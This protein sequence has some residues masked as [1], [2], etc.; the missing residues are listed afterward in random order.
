MQYEWEGVRDEGFYDEKGRGLGK[1]KKIK[2]RV[3]TRKI[4]R[5]KAGYQKSKLT[6][7]AAAAEVQQEPL[8]FHV[9]I[10]QCQYDMEYWKTYQTVVKL[11]II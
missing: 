3:K 4:L 6:A 7:G 9:N 5:E 1:G 11:K 8:I 2:R 10:R